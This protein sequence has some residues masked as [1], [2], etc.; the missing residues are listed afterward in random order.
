MEEQLEKSTTRSVLMQK[1]MSVCPLCGKKIHGRD[2][3]IDGL[4]EQKSN[5]TRWPVPY[6]HCHC[7]ENGKMHAL[8]L[9]LD[10]NFAVRGQEISEFVKIQK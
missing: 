5:I 4:A 9:Y 6:T 3:D 1:L 10:A 2:I 7:H 8:T